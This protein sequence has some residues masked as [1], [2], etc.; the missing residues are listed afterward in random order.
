[1]AGKV[2]EPRKCLTL[3]HSERPNLCTRFAF[4]CA[5]G[6][7]WGYR[8]KECRLVGLKYEMFF[9]PT[10]FDIS[11]FDVSR[12]K[13]RLVFLKYDTKMKNTTD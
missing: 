2:V 13:R 5:I 4:L 12:V 9:H 7:S 1:M 11:R 8:L 3:L 6:L 10:R